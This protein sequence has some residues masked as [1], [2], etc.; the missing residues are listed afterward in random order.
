M[1]DWFR[2]MING[3]TCFQRAVTV[4]PLLGLV[5]FYAFAL[6]VSLAQGALVS[7]GRPDAGVFE[8]QWLW[9]DM[10]VFAVQVGSFIS[11]GIVML[12]ATFKR[13][14]RPYKRQATE[15]SHWPTSTAILPSIL[16]SLCFWFDPMG[17]MD[18]YF[19]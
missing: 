14:S 1:P 12:A 10:T 2:G 5:V 18:W 7:Y 8:A 15:T 17:L 13:F 19:D 4:L 3:R 16:W 11:V 6:A 9:A